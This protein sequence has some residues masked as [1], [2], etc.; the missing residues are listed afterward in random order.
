MTHAQLS[1]LW[2]SA[3]T[4]ANRAVDT[5]Q[6]AGELHPEEC[7]RYRASLGKQQEAISRLL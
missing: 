2:Q 6:R 1:T 5:A 7:A 4:A 3:L